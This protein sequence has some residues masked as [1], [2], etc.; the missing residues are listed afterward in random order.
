MSSQQQQTFIIDFGTNTIKY[1]I[2]D[3]NYNE[4][5]SILGIYENQGDSAI[6]KLAIGSSVYQNEKMQNNFKRTKIINFIERGQVNKQ[7]LNTEHV[8]T[9][10]N[11]LFKISFQ[12]LTNENYMQFKLKSKDFIFILPNIQ[13]KEFLKELIKLCFEKY[14]LRS[15][16]L[17]NPLSLI[18]LVNNHLNKNDKLGKLYLEI[19]H[20]LTQCGSYY[21]LEEENNNTENNDFRNNFKS[22]V[23]EFGGKDINT[24]LKDNLNTKDENK[25]QEWKEKYLNCNPNINNNTIIDDNNNNIPNEILEIEPNFVKVLTSASN[26]L[27]NNLTDFINHYIRKNLN[28]SKVVI[29]IILSGGTTLLNGFKDRLQYELKKQ[30]NLECNVKHSCMG[31]LS[32]YFGACK[33]LEKNNNGE[34]CGNKVTYEQYK[35]K[36]LDRVLDE[37]FSHAFM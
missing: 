22:E 15:I 25:I 3:C 21:Y 20:G 37:D 5:H 7:N 36:G 26:I 16:Q 30:Y 19:G 8:E 2:N 6:T 4:F 33:L 17:E 31:N 9:F 35:E 28:N 29:E 27:F 10:L 32:V 24:Y 34:E 14:Q 12:L 18:S 13:Q 23:L 1:G 11:F